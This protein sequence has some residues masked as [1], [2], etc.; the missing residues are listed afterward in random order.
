MDD[1]QLRLENTLPITVICD[2]IRDPGSMGILLRVAAAINAE[3]FIAMKGQL[4]V[5]IY[6][7]V[8]LYKSTR[9]PNLQ[10]CA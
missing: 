10:G 2:Q 6:A 1:L 8:L 5:L 4:V 7:S 3:Q 9:C